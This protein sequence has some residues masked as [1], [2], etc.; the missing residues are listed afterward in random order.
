MSITHFCACA[1]SYMRASAG[2]VCVHACRLIYPARAVLL[3][4]ASLDPLHFSTL[5]HKQHV[6]RKNILNF[7]VL[8]FSTNLSE[9]FL[10]L[11]R[12]QRDVVTEVKTSSCKVSGILL[13]L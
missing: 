5:P 2:C 6:V 8:I 9:T 10:F 13:R 3:I 4:V 12:I 7:N 11:R 1:Y